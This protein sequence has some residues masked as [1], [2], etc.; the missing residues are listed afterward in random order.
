MR[1][2]PFLIIFKRC[3]YL[4]L[5][6]EAHRFEILAYK[7]PLPFKGVTACEPISTYDWGQTPSMI[8]KAPSRNG[9]N[10]QLLLLRR[11]EPGPRAI[12]SPLWPAGLTSRQSRVTRLLPRPR[13]MHSF[14]WITVLDCLTALLSL[15]IFFAFH[16]HRKRRGLPYPPGPPPFPV[17]GNLLDVPKRSAWVAYQSMSKKHGTATFLS[18]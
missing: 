3:K 4:F 9:Q 11:F 7:P 10:C 2:V 16:D 8:C 18:S 5:S 13:I 14:P 12:K 15:H 6:G 1:L 17:I